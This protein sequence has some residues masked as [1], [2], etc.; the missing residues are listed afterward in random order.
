[1]HSIEGEFKITIEGNTQIAKT[2][3]IITLPPNKKHKGS[4]LTACKAV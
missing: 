1:M 2:G 4:A 3:D